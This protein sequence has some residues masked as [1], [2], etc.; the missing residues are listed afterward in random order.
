M[1]TRGVE[2]LRSLCNLLIHQNRDGGLKSPMQN[3]ATAIRTVH[4]ILA[5]TQLHASR[6]WIDNDKLDALIAQLRATVRERRLTAEIRTL[7][8]KRLAFIEF[9][10]PDLLS[11]EPVDALI[12]KFV[13]TKPESKQN[14][15]SDFVKQLHSGGAPVESFEQRKARIL[16][17]HGG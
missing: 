15:V 5:L 14:D 2:K 13:G 9:G 16:A 10:A 8:L 11:D 4:N 12:R 1:S 3:R 17:A 7:A 6:P